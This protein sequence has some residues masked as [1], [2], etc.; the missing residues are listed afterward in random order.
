M[1]HPT[2][3]FGA[4]IAMFLAITVG[5]LLPAHDLPA[6]A[7]DGFDKLEHLLGYSLL[8]GW[9]VL[10][11]DRRSTRVRAMLGVIAF[12]IAIEVAQGV[13]TTTREPDVFDA[14]AN[15][16]GA[17]IGQLVAFTGLA[18]VLRTRA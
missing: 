14:L 7:F 11:F 17:M 3:V 5:S 6:P 9:S 13:L 2:L 15:A 12:G 18:N 10:L 16:T 4:W 1:R 8:S